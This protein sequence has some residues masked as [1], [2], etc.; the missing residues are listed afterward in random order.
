MRSV[1]IYDFD[2]TIYRGD[3]SVDFIVHCFMRQPSLLVYTPRMAWSIVMYIIGNNSKEQVKQAMFSFLKSIKNPD[4]MVSSFWSK[5]ITKIKPWYLSQKDSSDIIITA[6]PEFLVSSVANKISVENIIA[7]DIDIGTGKVSGKNCVGEEKVR[8][9]MLEYP[10]VTIDKAYG[11]SASDIPMLKIAKNGYFVKGDSICNLKDYKEP[12]SAMFKSRSFIRFLVVGGIN[13]F[14]GIT[15]AYIASLF[16][17]IPQFAFVIGFTSGL[18]PSYFLNSTIAFRDYSYT[19]SKFLKFAISYLP[20]LIIQLIL[21]H[22]LTIIFNPYP[23][24][25]FILAV[26]I[27]TPVTFTLLSLYVFRSESS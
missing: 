24:I 10:N 8:R 13:A 14:I 2:S 20:N 22:G 9:L 15:F 19:L 3:S 17:G 5:S 1:N 4:D 7:T 23:L 6:S 26:S 25:T 27:A 21:V 16:I 11:D 18:I 12:R